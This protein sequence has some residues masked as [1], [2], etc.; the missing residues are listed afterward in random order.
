MRVAIHAKTKHPDLW[1]L[2][3][4]FGSVV[5]LAKELGTSLGSTHQWVSLKSYPKILTDEQQSQITFITG[6][7][8][9]ELWPDDLRHAIDDK[10]AA[11]SIDRFVDYAKLELVENYQARMLLPSPE[12]RMEAIDENIALLN[13]LGR[14]R[15]R[16][17]AAIKLRY[18][19][20]GEC[21]HTLE[22]AGAK[23]GVSKER[24]RQILARAEEKL[25]NDYRFRKMFSTGIV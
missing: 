20:G 18:G 7:S 23:M 4:K 19:L 1:P 22:S 12:D 11:K 10:Q 15:A 2:V 21:E 16:E 25:R 5:A 3:R 14:L 6:K 8:I 13:S 17:A 9:E 24:L